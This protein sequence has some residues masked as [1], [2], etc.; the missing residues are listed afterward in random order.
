MSNS[1]SL[2]PVRERTMRA[3]RFHETGAPDVLCCETLPVPQVGP[4]EVLVRVLSAGVNYADVMRRAGQPYPVPTPLPF[5]AGSEVAGVVCACGEG[6]DS[7]WMGRRVLGG[8]IMGGGYAQFTAL[9]CAG[10][11]PWP[12]G[13]DAYQAGTLLIQGTTAALALCD[14]GGL[15]AGDRVLVLGAAGGVG[16]WLLQLARAL[17]ASQVIGGVSDAAKCRH[18]TTLGAHAVD[19][20]Q[21]DWPG[22]VL[23]LT[24]GRGVDLLLDATTGELLR[25]GGECLAEWGRIVIYGTSSP[26]PVPLDLPRMLAR[27]QRLSGC[28]LG[29][30]F[31]QR[32]ARVAEVLSQLGDLV[33]V[34]AVVPAVHSVLPL[35]Q[36]AQAHQLMESRS[37]VGKLLLD[38]WLGC[39][40]TNY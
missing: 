12:D 3:V 21:P 1:S 24:E 5:N 13:L 25:Q 9:P 11:F 35:E 39:D 15:R 38:P 33:K 4:G 30:Y 32:P 29:A 20:S 31:Q 16:S 14:S 26:V 28:F 17:G 6:V 7:S 37:V 34:G 18:V 19:Y 10:L 27:N 22:Q 23:E 8:N 2:T 40:D 36:A